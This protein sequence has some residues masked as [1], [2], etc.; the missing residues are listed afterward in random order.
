MAKT[1]TDG[2]RRRRALLREVDDALLMVGMLAQMLRGYVPPLVHEVMGLVLGAAVAWHVVLHRRWFAALAHGRWGV[3]R[4]VDA[5]LVL[6][7]AASLTVMVVSGLLMADLT[8]GFGLG[9]AGPARAA[10]LLSVHL[11]F[12]LMAA[13]GGWAVRV[14][15]A[16]VLARRGPV[17]RRRRAV[18]WALTAVVCVAG[19]WAFVDLGYVGYIAGIVGFAPAYAAKPLAAYLLEVLLASVPW[20]CAGFSLAAALL[21]RRGSASG[22]F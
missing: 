3:F 6:G 17:S 9:L 19:L 13:H 20:C 16:A 18:T 8:G 21:P 7:C 22:T 12:V 14:S 5:V 2:A 10:H 1:M 11:G 4:A 15:H